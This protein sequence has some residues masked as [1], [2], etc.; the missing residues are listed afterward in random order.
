MKAATPFVLSYFFSG[1]V[2]LRTIKSA[3]ALIQQKPGSKRKN[4][5]PLVPPQLPHPLPAVHQCAD[6]V[7]GKHIWGELAEDVVC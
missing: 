7:V 1:E 3:S 6:P 2:S 5:P 4:N